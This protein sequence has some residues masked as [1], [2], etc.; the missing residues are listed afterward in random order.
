[1]GITFKTA[2]GYTFLLLGN[3]SVADHADPEQAD[4]SWPSL[5]DFLRSMAEEGISLRIIG[6]GFKFSAKPIA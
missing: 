1:M 5:E 3:G 6:N 4:M 2:D